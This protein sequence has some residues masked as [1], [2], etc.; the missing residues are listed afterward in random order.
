MSTEAET[1]PANAVLVAA[2]TPKLQ[3]FNPEEPELWFA[4]AEMQFE[5]ANPAITTSKTKF[6]YVCLALSPEIQRDVKDIFLNPPDDPYGAL[7]KC[8]CAIYRLSPVEV[9][10]RVLDAPMLGD[11]TASA[12]ASSMLQ[13]LSAEHQEHPVVY[14]SFLRRL[15]LDIRRAIEEDDSLDV[16]ELATA[17]DRRL[18][19]RTMPQISGN[20]PIA[21]A[22]S[23]Q[24]RTKNAPDRKPLRPGNSSKKGPKTW[25]WLHR[26]FG[27]EARNCA[28]WCKWPNYPVTLSEIQEN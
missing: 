24:P 3:E 19:G 21:T 11:S 27:A 23:A 9:A 20:S 18:K 10:S 8:L 4:N 16:R 12:L 28:G 7:K 15:P 22:T 2:A 13:H 25:C 14:E 5:T 6:K 1:I 26:K 17:A